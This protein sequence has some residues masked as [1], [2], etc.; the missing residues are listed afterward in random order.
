MANELRHS[1]VGTALSKT[2][3]EAVGSHVLN[4]Q[5]AGDLIYASS[6]SQLSRLAIGSANQFLVTNSGG[7]APTWTSSPAVVTAITPDASDGATLGTAALEWS[8]LYMADGAVIYFGDDDDV[9]LTHVHNDGLLLSSTDQLQFGDSGTYIYQST[10]G[11]LDLVADT[12]IQIA[13]TTIDINGA[14][15]LNGA[16][17]GATNITLSGELDAATLDISGNADI[18]GTLEA[19]AYTVDGTTLAEYIADT[20]GAMVSSNTESGGIA[21][22]YEDG[23]NTLDFAISS[24]NASTVT[25]VDS[26]DTSSYI[27]MFDSATG[28]LAAKTDAGITYNAGTGMLTATGFTG[29]LTGT[30]QTAAQGN[31]TSL[32]T[33][34]T[35]TVDNVIIN[36][37][38]I[39][40][41]GDTD[42]MTLASTVLTVAGEVDA[43]TLDISSSADIAGDLVLSGGADGALQFTNAGEN[44]IKI[45]D[46][47]ASAL[48]IEE[49]DNAY[50][51]FVTSNGSEAITVA[52]ATTFSAGIANAG[53]IAAGTWNGTAI[54][55]SYI[56]AD[57]ITGAK[58]ADDAIDSEHYTDGSIDTAHVADNAITLAKMAHGTDG[59]LITYDA[60][61]APAVVA[62]GNDGQLLTSAGAG[63]P[64]A[65]E[66]APSAGGSITL[67][68]DGSIAAGAPVI[69]T[70]AG[71]A[72]QMQGV[73]SIF[74]PVGYVPTAANPAYYAA[75]Y[76]ASICFVSNGDVFFLS[77]V[78]GTGNNPSGHT[79]KVDATSGYDTTVMDIYTD[80]GDFSA[81]IGFHASIFDPQ[82]GRVM[83]IARDGSG[84]GFSHGVTVNFLEENNHEVTTTGS[85]HY[86]WD[87]SNASYRASVC[88][89][90]DVSKNVIAFSAYGSDSSD[91]YA[92]VATL[93][94]DMSVTYGTKSEFENANVD[95]IQV[96]D[97]PDQNKT[98]I[99][100]RDE[101]NSNYPTAI[102]ATV[103]AGTDPGLTY[104]SP[105]VIASVAQGT[106]A[107]PQYNKADGVCYD[108]NAD[109]IFYMY[110]DDT[111]YKLM[112][113]VGTVSGT[114]ITF[115]T[116]V[117]VPYTSGAYGGRFNNERTHSGYIASSGT[118]SFWYGIGNEAAVC[119]FSPDNNKICVVLSTDEYDN[120]GYSAWFGAGH[121]LTIVT[122]GTISGTS[123]TFTEPD[124]LAGQG[125]NFNNTSIEYDT[126]NNRVALV[127]GFTRYQNIANPFLNVMFAAGDKADGFDAGY[128]DKFIGFNAG[129]VSNAA[130][131]TITVSGGLNENQSSLEVG[132]KYYLGNTGTLSTNWMKVAGP[133]TIHAG[134]TQAA[135]KMLVSGSIHPSGNGLYTLYADKA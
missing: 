87:G 2:E 20:V 70:S 30:L 123:V 108:T 127:T 120:G 14:L 112:A 102:V 31:V 3:W 41:T 71:K 64:P 32:G 56:A 78:A 51:T 109:K 34:T 28:D 44:S 134:V 119:C 130:D 89:N 93:A 122:T 91:G 101:G 6:T 50:M 52:K 125:T 79:F 65:F 66:D 129:G 74:R 54:A 60:N 118:D 67:V 25:V 107:L 111:N 103:G 76:N 23:D 45:P 53:T 59:N 132:Q 116:P 128:M 42:L 5:A 73:W 92:I 86:D 15:A 84:I 27:A 4:S 36:G 16:I 46:N 38:T 24:V 104:G 100:Y 85:T 43:T 72:K 98:V 49:A 99:F 88:H 75:K 62:T 11:Q 13:A 47:Q 21:V 81:A 9:T 69:M 7:T 110:Q 40:H 61:G 95:C 83:T 57:A 96:V 37:T 19:D 77:T 80:T 17:T 48:I 126:T 82:A 35:L 63:Q 26:T 135:T 68:A 22:T 55:S 18:D 1:D 39:G 114:S 105:T 33:L 117:P 58:I 29:P 94:A 12:E 121:G 8:D 124:I 115:G 106:G 10:D 131:A 97:D 90:T 113:V 133:L